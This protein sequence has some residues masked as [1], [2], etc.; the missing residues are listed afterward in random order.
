MDRRLFLGGI[1]TG[2]LGRFYLAPADSLAADD[3]N[4]ELNKRTEEGVEKGLDHFK[5]IQAPDGHWEGPGGQNPTAMTGVAG[6]TML[7]EGSTLKEGKY[8]DQVSKAVTWFLAPQR[9][10]PNGLLGNPQNPSEAGRYMYGHGYGTM[11]LACAYG[12]E[13]DADQ[14][15]KLEAAL[16]KAVDFIAKA[17]TTRKHRKAEG[18][19][20]EIGGWGYT[21]AADTG[22]GGFDEGSVTITQ[23]QALRACRNAGIKVP[24]ETIDKATAYLEAST[25]PNGGVIYSYAN[26]GGVATNG[27]E[28]PSLTAAGVAC[29]F[30]AG[31][32]KTDLA[33]KWITFCKKNI[34]FA[35]GRILHEEYTNYYFAQ[36]V[37]ILGDDRYGEMFPNEPKDT[38]LVWS[39]FKE[40]MYPYLLDSQNK[41]TGGWEGTGSYGAGPV[42]ITAVNLS[43]L[44]LEK[45]ILP[46]YQR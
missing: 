34:Q 25:T 33:K 32:Y 26:S 44:Q 40:A 6:M 19:E 36:A 31:Q 9:Q 45:G 15:K 17:Q 22:G 8:S 10:Q 4:K 13:E 3:K 43:I 1:A 11:F 14:R 20:V 18:K 16:T 23:L 35:K 21:S 39:K 37:Y 46:L 12:E 41:T 29:A 7:M 27:N 30:S 28:R 2:T 24:K 38:W 5:K 42:F